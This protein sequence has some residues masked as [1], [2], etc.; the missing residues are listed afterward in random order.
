[1]LHIQANRKISLSEVLQKSNSQ[2]IK[3]MT[4]TIQKS[5]I[6]CLT[7]YQNNSLVPSY[8]AN[9]LQHTGYIKMMSFS[10]TS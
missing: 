1:M 7:A 8:S 9:I 10:F 4:K 3:V 2:A 5:V 6:L